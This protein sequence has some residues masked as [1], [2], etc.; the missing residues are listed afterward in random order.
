LLLTNLLRGMC[1]FLINVKDLKK[2]A[3]ALKGLSSSKIQKFIHNNK[4]TVLFQ[5][6]FTC[7]PGLNME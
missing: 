6:Q 4:D 5:V 7:I 1:V 2:L 3:L